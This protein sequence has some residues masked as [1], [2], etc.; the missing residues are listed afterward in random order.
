MMTMTTP[1]HP[2]D[3]SFSLPHLFSRLKAF[4]SRE[5]IQAMAL[6]VGAGLVIQLLPKRAIIGTATT[7]GST[8]IYPAL[9][10]LGLTKAIEISFPAL[11]P[12]GLPSPPP[13]PLIDL[14][15]DSRPSQW[16]QI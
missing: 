13:P 1:H 9:L 16:V 4:A 14:Q 11:R 12:C 7:L 15:D 3:S 2:A 5:P 8:L 10:T 6:A